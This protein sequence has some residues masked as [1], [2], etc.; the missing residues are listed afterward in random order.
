M[1]RATEDII[2]QKQRQVDESIRQNQRETADFIQTINDRRDA[3]LLVLATQRD[4]QQAIIDQKF[5][6][7]ELNKLV[8]RNVDLQK[9]IAFY[10]TASKTQIIAS[11][12]IYQE[13]LQM[14]D[15]FDFSGEHFNVKSFVNRQGASNRLP[16]EIIEMILEM[17]GLQSYAGGGTVPGPTGRAQ[18]AVVHGGEEISAPGSGG[19]GNTYIYI[20]RVDAN[21]PADIEKLSIAVSQAQGRRT[22]TNV[23]VNKSFGR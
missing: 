15:D 1:Q 3:D 17:L 22:N 18:L 13:A 9:Q 10:Q 7:N 16:P 20:Q 6:Q 2:R 4:Q 23:R 14:L 12:R 5:E 8:E 11:S 19:G 21:N